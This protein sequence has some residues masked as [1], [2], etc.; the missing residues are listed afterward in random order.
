MVMYFHTK[1]ENLSSSSYSAWKR[2][3]KWL[4]LNPK[5]YEWQKPWSQDFMLVLKYS[6]LIQ[7][8]SCLF[9]FSFDVR[10]EVS[11]YLCTYHSNMR[12]T[13]L[14]DSVTQVDFSKKNDHYTRLL[15]WANLDLTMTHYMWLVYVNTI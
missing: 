1:F 6:K 10:S 11:K 2:P 15:I 12:S 7:L 4:P 5:I 3:L 9:I 13:Y 14:V 8:D